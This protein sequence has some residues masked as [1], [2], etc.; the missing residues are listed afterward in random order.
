MICA[1]E[2]VDVV[3]QEGCSHPGEA[4]CK[5]CMAKYIRERLE[6]IENFPV[7]CPVEGCDETISFQ[8]AEL[9]LEDRSDDHFKEQTE[10][11]RLAA[12]ARA[13]AKFLQFHLTKTIGH[14]VP[15]NP[16]SG[17]KLPHDACSFTHKYT[18]CGLYARTPTLFVH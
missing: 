3:V 7:K 6:N 14:M 18:L 4:I 15:V 9:V 16:I 8:T 1:K 2:E 11:Q 17:L 13:K 5:G 12:L 10:A